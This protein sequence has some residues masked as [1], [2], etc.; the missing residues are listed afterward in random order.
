MVLNHACNL[1]HSIFYSLKTLNDI[2]I[3]AKEKL[4]NLIKFDLQSLICY[5][6]II[7]F[8]PG[9]AQMSQNP[10]ICVIWKSY[11]TAYIE[12]TVNCMV[13]CLNVC[14]YMI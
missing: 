9:D 13:A 10:I 2:D 7:K 4:I 12:K 14:N 11:I 1:C 5:I 8:T 3:K 6:N